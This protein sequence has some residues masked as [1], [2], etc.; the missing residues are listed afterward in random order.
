MGEMIDMIERYEWTLWSVPQGRNGLIYT[1]YRCTLWFRYFW[2][3]WSRQQQ[4]QN[5][6]ASAPLTSDNKTIYVRYIWSN[7]TSEHFDRFLRVEMDSFTINTAA[8]YEFGI[9]E[10]MS[11]Q[12]QR[13]NTTDFAP[14]Q[15]TRPSMFDIYDQILRV[16][17]LIG[18]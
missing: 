4:R 5:T 2:S 17:T 1:Q 16:N 3:K 8:P 12:Q 7:A 15:T 11:R 10:V 9:F 14:L 18:S 13:Q 6:T